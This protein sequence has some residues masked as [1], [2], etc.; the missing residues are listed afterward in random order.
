MSTNN[1][2]DNVDSDQGS[3]TEVDETTPLLE[4]TTPK[5]LYIV[6]PEAQREEIWKP[7]PGF[8]WIETGMRRI[9]HLSWTALVGR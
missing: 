6:S 3:M 8:W 9:T 7:S 5:T 1:S 2:T 4:S